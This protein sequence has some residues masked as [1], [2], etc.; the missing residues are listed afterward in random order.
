[1]PP[2]EAAGSRIQLFSAPNRSHGAHILSPATREVCSPASL[3]NATS[4]YFCWQS[5]VPLHYFVSCEGWYQIICRHSFGNQVSTCGLI[6]WQSKGSSYASSK[7][8]YLF[9]PS[10]Q[11]QDSIADKKQQATSQE[12]AIYLL[13]AIHI[14]QPGHQLTSTKMAL[15]TILLSTLAALASAFPL[16][17]RAG[18]PAIVSIPTDCP[19]TNPLP[20]GNGLMPTPATLYQ[21]Y[22]TD[23]RPAAE[24]AQQCFDQCYGYGNPGSCKAAVLAYNVPTPAGYYGTAGGVLETSCMLFA[25]YLQES[26]F[27]AAPGGQYTSENAT[28]IYC[29]RSS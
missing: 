9:F 20:A 12:L 17:K 1:M 13:P 24:V 28:N 21:A 2:A 19:Q 5:D 22:Y 4:A 27:A 7:Y 15:T 25:D 18:G 14:H 10:Q 16:R 11:L 6:L 29:Q 23:S 26:D 3:R 8:T